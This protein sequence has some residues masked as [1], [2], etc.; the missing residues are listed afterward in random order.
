MHFEHYKFNE[1]F[2]N[3]QTFCSKNG[4]CSRILNKYNALNKKYA[5]SKILQSFK[6]MSQG[7]VID[8]MIIAFLQLTV[9]QFL[10]RHTDHR[11]LDG[12]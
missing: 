4:V 2:A 9:L 1:H 11:N 5:F 3:N 12:N 6:R 7:R 10:E 8:I